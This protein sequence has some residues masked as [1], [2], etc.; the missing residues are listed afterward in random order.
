MA[1]R[2][3]A[4]AGVVEGIGA[5]LEAL[6]RPK[7]A[8]LSASEFLKRRRTLMLSSDEGLQAPDAQGQSLNSTSWCGEP[9]ALA[10]VA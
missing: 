8:R 3:I 2:A 1:W 4:A 5:E 9:S 7:G 6:L 10:D